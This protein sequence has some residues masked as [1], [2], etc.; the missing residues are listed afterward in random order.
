MKKCPDTRSTS[1]EVGGK[2]EKPSKSKGPG[3]VSV[4]FHRSQKPPDSQEIGDHSEN[5][6]LQKCL[7][8]GQRGNQEK[9]EQEKKDGGKKGDGHA[10]LIKLQTESGS[11]E[12]KNNEGDPSFFWIKQGVLDHEG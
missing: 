3:N 11:G 6:P 10:L 9:G 7:G 1:G 8:A 5:G 4:V 12:D 2:Q